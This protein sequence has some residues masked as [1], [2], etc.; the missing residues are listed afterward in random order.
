MGNET[1][2]GM[3][4]RGGAADRHGDVTGRRANRPCLRL[5]DVGIVRPAA[6][7]RNAARAIPR[8]AALLLPGRGQTGPPSWRKRM[9]PQTRPYIGVNTDF[10]PAHK[11]SPAQVRLNMGY[12]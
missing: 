2:P 5:S 10:L 12:I 3:I 8:T 11:L 6:R 4:P 9:A 1:T 7:T